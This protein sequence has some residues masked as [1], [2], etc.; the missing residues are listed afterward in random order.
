VSET[1]GMRQAMPLPS[2]PS[3]LR[4]HEMDLSTETQCIYDSFTDGTVY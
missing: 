1:L 2:P 3:V 4:D